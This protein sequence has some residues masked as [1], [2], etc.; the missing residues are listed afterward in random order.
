MSDAH[1]TILSS[2]LS[3]L[4]ATISATLGGI[5]LTIVL[6]FVA[7]LAMLSHSRTVRFVSRVYVEGFRGTSEV[8]QLFWL[9]FVLPALVGLKLIPLFAGILVLGLNH[10][11]YGAEVVR[12]AVQSVPRAQREGALALSLSPA[13]RMFRVLLPQALVEMYPPFNNLFIQL[14][15][16]TAL[17]YFISAG[18][19][20][21]K[22]ELLRPVFGSDLVFIYGV[23]LVCYLVLAV[24]ITVVMRTLERL[25]ARRLGRAPAPRRKWRTRM[26]RTSEVS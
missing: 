18:E 7:G 12:G 10:G 21:E 2:I 4:G 20:T 13:Q 22:G 25:A 17:L 15:K 19:I 5:L 16:S 3:G 8:V 6:S 23:E 9:Y 14:L 24:I 26:P 11:A 1:S